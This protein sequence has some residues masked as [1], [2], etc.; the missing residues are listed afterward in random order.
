MIEQKKICRSTSVHNG[1]MQKLLLNFSHDS[2][3]GTPFFFFLGG[4][5]EY[6]KFH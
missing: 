4:G 2:H 5:G 3:T 6:T 1:D